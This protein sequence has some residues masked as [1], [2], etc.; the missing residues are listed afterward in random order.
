MDR[1]AVAALALGKSGTE[2]TLI[3]KVHRFRPYV[4]ERRPA[5]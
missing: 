1:D 5:T 2:L 3:A 4:A